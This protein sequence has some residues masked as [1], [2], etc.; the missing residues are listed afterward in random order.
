LAQISCLRKKILFEAL[1][2]LASGA[3][4]CAVGEAIYLNQI[5]RLY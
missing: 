5:L 3:F 1:L 2:R 4:Y